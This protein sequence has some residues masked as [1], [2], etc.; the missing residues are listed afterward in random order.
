MD[1]AAEKNVHVPNVARLTLRGELNTI[2]SW[3][4]GLVLDGQGG[5]EPSRRTCWPSLST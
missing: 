5:C 4:V 3:L 1:E 2:I